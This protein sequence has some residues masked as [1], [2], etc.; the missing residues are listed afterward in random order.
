MPNDP[1]LHEFRALTLFALKRYD[2]AAAPLYAVL[3]V[4]PGWDWTTLISLYADPE[5]YTQQLRALESLLHPEPES[6]AAH[7]VLAYQYLTEEHAEA[8]VRAVEDRER[9]SAQGHALGAIDPAARAAGAASSAAGRRQ[10]KPQPPRQPPAPPAA[11]RFRPAR[12]GSWRGR[13]TAQ[14]NKDTKIT[15]ELPER[16]AFHLEGRPAREGPAV[17]REVQL[18]ER[19]PDAGPGPEQQHDGRQR[20]AG[21]TRTISRSR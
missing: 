19:H 13:W 12:K 4:G 17:R 10:D 2:E 16:R 7:F 20:A 21:R 1:T 15:V 5:T 14:P 9:P 8:A 18:R 3:S 6:A 11:D